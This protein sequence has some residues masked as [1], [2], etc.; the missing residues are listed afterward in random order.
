MLE[1]RGIKYFEDGRSLLDTVGGRRFRVVERDIKDGYQVANVEFLEDAIPV[2]SDVWE[3]Q[4]TTNLC[5]V[6][7]CLKMIKSFQHLHDQTLANA[8]TWLRCHHTQRKEGILTHF[9]KHTFD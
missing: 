2:D 9:G 8:L 4:V 5:L 3:L 7:T 6:K 1:I